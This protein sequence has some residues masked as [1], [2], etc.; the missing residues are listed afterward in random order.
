MLHTDRRKRR[1]VGPI[2][3]DS[4]CDSTRMVPCAMHHADNALL[5]D[6][7]GAQQHERG[8]P[9]VKLTVGAALVLVGWLVLVALAVPGMPSW[10]RGVLE[11]VIIVT[12]LLAV[13]SSREASSIWSGFA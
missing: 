2:S 11:A 4:D 8:S 9:A 13:A 6:L 5:H 7:L 10:K 12:V 3:P 1:S